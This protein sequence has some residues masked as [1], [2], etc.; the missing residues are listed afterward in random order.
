MTKMN[1]NDMKNR[2]IINII[3]MKMIVIPMIAMITTVVN[4]SQEIGDVIIHHLP[5]QLS[6]LSY[7]VLSL[8][9]ACSD[10]YVS[11]RALSAS[12]TSLLSC[13]SMFICCI[14]E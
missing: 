1:R 5:A 9:P 13:L 4:I 12:P 10:Y 11:A 3:V 8:F 2:T 14:A 6:H 7:F